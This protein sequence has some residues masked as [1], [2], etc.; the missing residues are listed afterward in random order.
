M[1]MVHNKIKKER[2]HLASRQESER[3]VQTESRRARDEKW[4]KH[5]AS[6]KRQ[7]LEALVQVHWSHYF[8][9]LEAIAGRPVWCSN[10]KS[11]GLDIRRKLEDS[12]E[13]FKDK[14]CPDGW[15]TEPDK[16]WWRWTDG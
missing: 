4:H 8:N 9:L 11:S 1:G 3:L 14:S 13:M 12:G 15:Y 16:D 10:C 7:R 5:A 2:K 6:S